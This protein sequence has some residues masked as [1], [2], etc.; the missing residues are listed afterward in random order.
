MKSRLR[1]IV[2]AAATSVVVGI[3]A[4]FATA[5]DSGASATRQ[6][7]KLTPGSY[8][9]NTTLNTKLEVPRPKGTTSGTGTFKATLKVVSA[10]KASLTWKLTFA[11]LT[12]P[13]LA[14]H[15]HLGAPG[16][17]GKVVVPLCGPCRSGRG[18][19]T[20]VTAVAAAAMIAGKAYVNVHTKA[21]PNG[22]IRGTVKAPPPAAGRR[23][24]VRE[25]HRRVD[26]RARRPGQG[27]LREVRLRGLPYVDRR[28]VDRPDVEG[29]RGPQQSALTTGQ[30]CTRDRRLPDQRDRAARRG[31][32]RGLLV[33]HHV[34]GDRKH[35]ARA[36]EGDRRLHQ[37]GQVRAQHET[38]LVRDSGAGR[39]SSPPFSRVLFGAMA[40]AAPAAATK[41]S[42]RI[43]KLSPLTIRG[44]GFKPAERVTLTLSAGA[45]GTAK[46]TAT[47][48]GVL[49]VSVPKAKVTACT[50]Y[51]LRAVGSAGTR[52]TFKRTVGASCKP[53]ATLKFTGTDVV[54]AGTNF[55]PG[56]KLSVNLV[57]GGG[58][59][60][61][62]ATASAAGCVHRQ[63]RRPPDERLHPVY[64]HDHGLPREPVR[65]HAGGAPVLGRLTIAG[66]VGI[67]AFV[68][69]FCGSTQTGIRD[70]G[71][72]SPAES[73][74]PD[75]GRPDRRQPE[76]RRTCGD[77]LV[78]RRQQGHEEAQLPRF[79]SEDEAARARPGRPHR[80]VVRGPR[81]LRV[82][83]RPQLRSPGHARE[84]RGVL[85]TRRIGVAQ[86]VAGR[87]GLA[88][89]VA[90]LGLLS[91]AGCG[92]TG[93]AKPAGRRRLVPAE[94]KRREH[95]CRTRPAGARRRRPA[96]GSLA[97]PASRG[98]RVLRHR[99]RDAGRLGGRVY[100]QDLNSDVYALSLAD[101]HL[102][103][104][105]RYRRPDGGPNGLAVANGVVYGNTDTSAFA[106][107]ARTGVERWRSRLTRPG[108]PVTIAPLVANG[109][110][111]TSS[112]GQSPGGRGTL[113]A[114][115]TR[116]RSGAL[117]VRHDRRSLA[118]PARGLGRRRLASAVG[119][120]E[121]ARLLGNRQSVSLGRVA[122]AG[123]TEGCTRGPC[124]TPTRSSSSTAGRASCSGA[125][126]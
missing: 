98:A 75:P 125:T 70:D 24:P 104:R 45:A 39:R 78:P 31:D 67:M 108:N 34:D 97:F 33:R 120:C 22:E 28:G 7:T 107:S 84:H 117:E 13:A 90:S 11:H 35:P 5:G 16:K 51:T 105:H 59:H 44:S 81:E 64:T 126:R 79:G 48:A 54:L 60:K 96:S 6:A 10:T 114:L 77:D 121:G 62:S 66:A 63:L 119:G 100:L 47:A 123:R 37:V 19:T 115:D 69:L 73:L 23:Q 25:H 58:A 1:V 29:A 109:L 4:G 111:Y 99:C 53:A 112:T 17:A 56:E 49:T 18:A 71:G 15:V 27:A 9:I 43:V 82:P 32:H 52:V 61:K 94:R 106:L 50:P 55:R 20:S 38:S 3:A 89:L 110:V 65:P 40:T 95:T 116:D 42:L 14:A 118:L 124:G 68:S 72:R 113:F 87:V 92:G 12:G 91:L 8:K 103:W 101:G 21:N 76:A 80:A 30:V 26:A 83:L 85:G 36:G 2:I 93:E 102:L 86:P 88:A 57:E 122:R 74:R 41:A 46:G